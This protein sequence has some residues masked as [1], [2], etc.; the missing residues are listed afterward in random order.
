MGATDAVV[1]GELFRRK[2]VS[3]HLEGCKR[4]ARRDF[5]REGGEK[6]LGGQGEPRC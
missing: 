2:S 1:L 4:A 3:G 5:A 6:G